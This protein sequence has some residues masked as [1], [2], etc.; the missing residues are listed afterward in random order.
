MSSEQFETLLDLFT[1]RYEY[2]RAI[3]PRLEGCRGE[4][5]KSLLREFDK[6]H[7][8]ANEM[9]S[10]MEAELKDA[11]R[12]YQNQMANKMRT[13]R[14]VLAELQRDARNTNTGF[15]SDG[16][17][18]GLYNVEDEQRATLNPQRS[19]LLQGHESLN[20]TT[21][22]IARSH[23]LAAETDA[24]GHNIVEELG[25]QREQLERTKDRL[26]NTGENLSKSRKILRSMSRKIVTNKLFLSIIII[27]EIAILGAVVYLK[28]FRKT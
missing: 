17:R 26:V 13:Y 3:P 8:E 22:S 4:Q 18:K 2:L 14:K 23:Y 27:L 9:L 10:Q 20:R 28:F 24:I 21:E 12:S 1:E 25:E 7:L 5:H 6:R 19:L 16:G 11:P 15:M